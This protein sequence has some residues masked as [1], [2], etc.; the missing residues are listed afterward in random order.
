[1]SLSFKFNKKKIKFNGYNIQT[2]SFG[3]GEK[4]VLSFPG[5]PHSGLYFTLFLRFYDPTRVK[6]ITFD[7]P[8][9]FGNSE[10]VFQNSEFAIETYVD[11]AEKILEEYEVKKFNI[12][13]YSFGSALAVLIA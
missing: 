6:F 1:M 3:A 4:V 2:Y 12:I 7:L 8:G 5:F 13:G 9:W 10:N 11:I